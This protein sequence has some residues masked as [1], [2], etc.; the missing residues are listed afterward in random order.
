LLAIN[1]K[2]QLATLGRLLGDTTEPAGVREHVAGALAGL[3]QPESRAELLKV[4]PA[5]PARLQSAIAAGLAGSPQRAEALL[6]AVKAGKE[7]ARLLLEKPVE[8]RL[9]QSKL[10][11]L[12][13]RVAK[14]TAGLPAVDQKLQEAIQRRRDGF[15]KAKTD[16]LLGAKIFEKN[17]ANCHQI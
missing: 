10:P 14:L 9:N 15:G 13:E 4:L 5:A 2:G 1:P 16:V 8:L 17:C 3:N 6:D 11:D 12:K 7:S